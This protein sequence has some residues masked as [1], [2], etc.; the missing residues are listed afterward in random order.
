MA[1]LGHVAV[2]MAAARVYGGERVPRWPGFAFW[3]ALSL[4]PDADVVGFALGVGYAD[5]WGHR[6]ATHSLSFAIL[7]GFALGVAAGWFKRPAHRTAL[8]AAAVL[9]SHP[10]LDTLTDGGLGC[11]LLWPFDS[12]RYFAPWRPITV[13]PIGLDF[14]TPYGALIALTELVLFAPLFGYAVYSR[15]MGM[16][17]VATGVFLAAWLAA[18]WLV[19]ARDPIREGVVGF[20]LRE[21]TIYA[22]GFS[23][24]AFRTIEPG[25]PENDVRRVLGAPVRERWF[26][27]PKG[28][29]FESAALASASQ[30]TAGCRAIS[31]EA[32]TVVA[33]L[34]ADACGEIG[35]ETG[36]SVAGVRQVLGAPPESCWG[37]TGSPRNARYRLRMVCFSNGTVET[38]IRRWE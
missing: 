18:A 23:E 38:V 15:R 24:H 25:T 9:A 32:G 30:M 16:T 10:I 20:V 21:D 6:G 33:A 12:T 31:F 19:L 13:A 26:Y 3:S 28:R 7:L 1:T 35:I 22:S 29:A 11:A 27:A 5:P 34:N 17:R 36:M 8:A 2:G 14:F 4:L 37:Y